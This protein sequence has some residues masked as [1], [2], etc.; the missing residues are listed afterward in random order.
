MKFVEI[1]TYNRD[2]LEQSAF[3]T[4]DTKDDIKYIKENNIG[5][6]YLANTTNKIGT[7]SFI[8]NIVNKPD[9][10]FNSSIGTLITPN[11]NLTFNLN[12]VIKDTIFF[13]S[14]PAENELLVTKPTFK[15][16]KY[17][18][19]NVEISVQIVKRTGLRILTI[20]Y[21]K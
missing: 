20:E 11:G 2:E 19:F 14:A 10:I 17:T 15:G 12:Y 5:N 8:N 3:I 21:E 1:Y 18:D 6:L 16:G 9:V 13:T 7:I 4:I